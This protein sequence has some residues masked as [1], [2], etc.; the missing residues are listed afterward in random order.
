MFELFGMDGVF[1]KAG[2]RLIY[3]LTEWFKICGICGFRHGLAGWE[4]IRLAISRYGV[5]TFW[6]GSDGCSAGFKTFNK[7]LAVKSIGYGRHTRRALL[8]FLNRHGGSLS[9][10]LRLCLSCFCV[11]PV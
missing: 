4:K 3:G 10:Y 6:T 1:G 5:Y 9:F 2:A 11:S 7:S 8:D